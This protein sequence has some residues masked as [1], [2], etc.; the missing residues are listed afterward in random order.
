MQH[1]VFVELSSLSSQHRDAN[2]LLEGGEAEVG[3]IYADFKGNILCFIWLNISLLQ[4]KLAF[5]THSFPLG[6]IWLFFNPAAVQMK[7]E[8]VTCFGFRLEPNGKKATAW[9]SAAIAGFP[10]SEG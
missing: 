1:L 3:G 2:S 8:G 9:I 6:N 5:Q 7:T 4:G 10:T